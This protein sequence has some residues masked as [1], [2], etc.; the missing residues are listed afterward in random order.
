MVILKGIQEGFFDN[1]E[2]QPAA[3]TLHKEIESRSK[4]NSFQEAWDLFHGSFQP[5]ADEVLGKMAD[6]FKRSVETISPINLAGTVTL[7]NDLGE[8][9]EMAA[10]LGRI[11]QY[12]DEEEIRR[13]REE[14]AQHQRE[15]DEKRQALIAKFLA[16]EDS[17]WVQPSASEDVFCRVNGRAYHLS[18]KEGITRKLERIS[19]ID[20]PNPRLIGRYKTRAEATKVIQEIAYKPEPRS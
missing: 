12:V 9:T 4:D 8:G 17:K 16:G 1:D 13:F 18:P 19:T 7:F 6:A 20:D 15:A 14:M 11:R 2:I 3:Q 5:N 10:I